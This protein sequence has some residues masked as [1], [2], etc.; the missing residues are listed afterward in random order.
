MSL[1]NQWVTEEDKKEIKKKIPR[2][3]WK[4]KHDDPKPIGCY[5]S[6]SKNDVCSNTILLQGKKIQTIQEVQYRD[7]KHKKRTK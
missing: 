6:S 7:R 2:D 5:K 4:W 1:N 3:R